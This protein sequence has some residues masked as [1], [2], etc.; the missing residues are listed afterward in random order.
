MEALVQKKPRDAGNLEELLAAEKQELAKR[1]KAA[2][3]QR[4]KDMRAAAEPIN[5]GLSY[6]K[7]PRGV[8][9]NEVFELAEEKE[10]GGGKPKKEGLRLECDGN[11]TSFQSS[12]N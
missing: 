10:E 11:T 9:R 12:L 7:L 8:K 2:G 5:A 4:Q 3:K 1:A 6:L